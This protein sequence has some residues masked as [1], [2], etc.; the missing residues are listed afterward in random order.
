MECRT[1]LQQTSCGAPDKQNDSP[2]PSS[3]FTSWVWGMKL[4][5]ALVTSD[6]VGPPVSRLTEREGRWS[7]SHGDINVSA[8]RNGTTFMNLLLYTMA[9]TCERF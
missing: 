7:R 5:S 3:H 2:I 1:L 9:N 4:D 8:S 6:G